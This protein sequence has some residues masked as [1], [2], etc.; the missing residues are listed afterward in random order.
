MSKGD[1]DRETA[2]L[3]QADAGEKPWRR[4]GPYLSERQWGTVREDYGADGDAWAYLPHEHAR[5]RAYR[6]GEDGLGGFCD[7][8]QILCLC[9]ALWNGNDPI[10]KERLFGLT[11]AEGNHGEDVKELYYYLDATPTY[12]YARML[13]KYPQAAYPYERLVEE[14]RSRGKQQ[15]EFELIDTGLFDEDRYFDVDI[16]YAKADVDDILLRITATNRGPQDARLHVLPQVWF[17]N[18]WDWSDDAKKPS[19]K[20]MNGGAIAIEHETLGSYTVQFEKPQDL[21]FCDNA[22][23]APKVFGGTDVDGY[24][25]D[26]FHEVLVNGNTGAANPAKT[27]T[28]AAGVY[29]RMVPAGR[30][31]VVRVRLGP[32][33]PRA[34]AFTDFDAVFRQRL[35]EAETYYANLQKHIPDEDAR[36]VQRQAF[37]GMLWSKQY[38]FYDI[39]AWLD[40]D[41]GQP[42]P[43][44]S[45]KSGR[46]SDWFH[47]YAADVISMPD[48]WEYPWFAAWDWAFHLVTL[49]L[50]DPRFAKDQLVLL[51]QVWYLH[52]NGQIPAYEWNFSDVNP[53]VHAWAALRIYEMDKRHNGGKG[54]RQFLERVFVKLLLN[55]T[56]WVNRKDPSGRNVFQ[57]G[58]LGLDNIGIFDRSAP[59]PVDG[60]LTQSDGTSWMAMFCLNMLR[61]ALELAQENPAYEDIAMKFGEHFLLIG[62]AMT[63][64]GDEGLGLW[65]D[66]DRF[67]YDWL[68]LSSGERIPLRLRSM[69]G[70]IP[71]F[72]VEI[73]DESL[74]AGAPE[75]NRRM[76]WYLRHRP[77]LAGLVSRLENTGPENCRLISIARAFRM[78]RVIER[79]LDE[80]EFLS[81]YGVRAIS[82]HYLDHPYVFEYGSYRS[83]VKYLPAESDS[84]MFG[85]NSNWRGPIWMPVNYLII[86]SL[87]KFGSFYGDDFRV[88]CPKGSGNMLCLDE[89][90]DELRNRLT[91]LFLR[92]AD[93]RRPVFNGNEKL[94]TDPHFKDY[95]LFHEYFDGDDGHGVGASHQTGWTGLVANLIDELHGADR[96][97]P[98]DG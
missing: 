90:A 92:D 24:F 2:R 64:L 59:L 7:D 73:L 22:T 34:E 26:A 14:N 3:Q 83:E 76:M 57:G 68:I 75:F 35:G 31:V 80:S 84:G 50:I 71:L 12:G 63:N 20:A 9:V 16:E 45:R 60:T 74:L 77:E 25:K 58:F 79:M 86:E 29:A 53:P 17:R 21:L 61:I 18:T 6:W 91:R 67:Y 55:F 49:A 28:K 65:D 8:Q 98:A 69:V 38:Y 10:L 87:C 46:N 32:G 23:N 36:R 96:Q 41:P 70:L 27:G 97:G 94:Q 40:G 43:P 52:P 15:P 72:A 33:Q 37:A 85:G 54:D 13:Y 62:G 48:K 19:L 88:E 95:L 47:F 81:P 1:S 39:R 42:E 56:W 44:P 82:R 5:S 11:N 93:G 51:C 30:N 78:K 4:W 66:Q 89:I